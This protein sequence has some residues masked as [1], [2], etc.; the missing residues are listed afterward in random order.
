MNNTKFNIKYKSI[1]KV[2]ESM[3]IDKYEVVRLN[4]H[5][6]EELTAYY[7]D[8]SFA[9]ILYNQDYKYMKEVG[10]GTKSSGDKGSF[11]KN[12]PIA[13][14]VKDKGET[15]LDKTSYLERVKS[16]MSNTI[17]TNIETGKKQL[18]NKFDEVR[19]SLIK[20]VI[21]EVRGITNLP[22][23]VPE[24]VYST[25][26]RQLSVKNF[27]R[28]LGSDLLNDSLNGLSGGLTSLTDL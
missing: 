22:K 15:I 17:K 9:G 12:N 28:G 20:D 7:G 3:L 27:A 8:D 4:T 1:S 2:F 11:D 5:N 13:N 24:N 25:D 26:F 18:I 14:I 16:N 10:E 19:G 21:K 6:L 23:I